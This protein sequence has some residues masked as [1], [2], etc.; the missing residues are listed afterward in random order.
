MKE[1]IKISNICF[2]RQNKVI[3]NK[4]NFSIYENEKVAIIGTNGSGKTSL[5]DIILNDIKPSTGKVYIN[6]N[7]KIKN[8]SNIGIAYD[9]LPLFPLLKVSEVIDYFCAIL[10]LDYKS[11][12]FEFFNSFDINI[13]SDSF[14]KDL[15]QGEK[16]RIGLLL[17]VMNNPKILILDEPFSSLDPTI[18]DIVWKAL[19]KNDR[20]IL[21]TT[22]NWK[23]IE[24][25]ASKVVFLH[26]G[27]LISSPKNPNE[28][29]KEI[30]E[31]KITINFD[32]DFLRKIENY[33]YY[34]HDNL[35]NVLYNENDIEVLK[36]I[37]EHTNNFSIQNV[38]I[39]DAYLYK[40]K[41][42]E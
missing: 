23:E 9:S 41:N 13:I 39:K 37:K 21:F 15:S 4:I 34:I 20:T 31:K 38:D 30:P 12:K 17:A 1:V 11:V 19:I 14:I 32:N 5:I 36:I 16:K 40:I 10:K 26:N 2:N 29:L 6:N 22:H 8:Y 25:I 35:I 27:I 28:I 24:T 3:L 18:I 7:S 42:Y 33:I